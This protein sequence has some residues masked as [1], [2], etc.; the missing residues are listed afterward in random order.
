MTKRTRNFL[1]IL[2]IVIF[3]ILTPLAFFYAAG[4][5]INLS[6][7]IHLNSAI[8][9]TGMFI[10]ETEPRGA[11]IFLNGE[12]QQLFLDKLLFRKE[13]IITTPAKI[14]GLLPGEYEVRL[15]KEGYWPWQKQLTIYPGLSTK[16]EN[17]QLFKKGLPLQISKISHENISK[18]KNFMISPNGS[19]IAYLENDQL[20]IQNTNSTEKIIH[21]L[22]NYSNY[23]SH[24]IL[25]SP[26]NKKL[27]YNNIIFYTDKSLNPI[28]LKKIIGE[29]IKNIKWNNNNHNQIYYQYGNSVNNFDLEKNIFQQLFIA[30]DI[31]DFLLVNEKLIIINK[32]SDKTIMQIISLSENDKKQTIELPYSSEYQLLDYGNK[33]I[34][35]YD[36]QHEILYLIDLN[37]TINPIKE[38]INNIKL[39]AWNNDE[40]LLYANDYEIWLLSLKKDTLFSGG[41]EKKLLTRLS[42][43]IINIAWHPNNNY[44]LYA[45][46]KSINIMDLSN[47]EKENITELISLN[48]I[49]NASF[50]P[51]KNLV[52]FSAKI[53]NKEGIYKLEL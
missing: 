2:F 15:E 29:G 12:S 38:T 42:Q 21:D 10:L 8:Q 6:W 47:Q 40:H 4:Y 5:K 35:L 28:N 23:E 34:H 27:I 53:G 48:N 9:K 3:L 1:F 19:Y 30:Q 24:K 31:K 25:W 33:Y 16:W 11:K 39:I 45:T 37:S 44:I 7:P 46:S 51:N 13:N 32:E 52:Y 41:N 43:K 36:A 17:I 22:N 18:S 20:I 50:L 26:D 14:Q 49:Y